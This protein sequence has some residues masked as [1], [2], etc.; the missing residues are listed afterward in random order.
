MIE[1]STPTGSIHGAKEPVS[2]P[3]L[4]RVGPAQI[5]LIDELEDDVVG[6]VETWVDTEEDDD[7]EK[8]ELKML[9]DGVVSNELVV[10][11][12]MA[13]EVGIKIE[14]VET[15]SIVLEKFVPEAAPVEGR[16]IVKEIML[17]SSVLDG[18]V[19]EGTRVE[20]SSVGVLVGSLVVLG[21]VV[22]GLIVLEGLSDIEVEDNIV[23]VGSPV[24]DRSSDVERAA[25]EDDAAVYVGSKE[26]DSSVEL[27]CS[28]VEVICVVGASEELMGVSAVPP[29]LEEDAAELVSGA[30]EKFEEDK[31]EPIP[32]VL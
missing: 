12:G 8:L 9:V 29:I 19:V 21:P 4:M 30:P 28:V 10:E 17:D 27:A 3:P 25:V 11:D 16:F 15:D 26:V 20:D 24:V 6:V 7:A 23:V 22:E 14:G 1:W 18:A 5:E 32:V 13:V 2:K 31:F